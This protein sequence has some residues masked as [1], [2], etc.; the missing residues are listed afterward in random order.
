[1]LSE[2]KYCYCHPSSADKQ[3]TVSTMASDIF[4]EWSKSP[5]PLQHNCPT[6]DV[7][8]KL[9]N[10]SMMDREL[11]ESVAAYTA[12]KRPSLFDSVISTLGTFFGL[13]RN[14]T[15]LDV[16]HSS[17]CLA[18][19]EQY[20]KQPCIPSTS[21]IPIFETNR[22]GMGQ[23]TVPLD[24]GSTVDDIAMTPAGVYVED[25]AASECSALRPR[26]VRKRRKDVSKTNQH[27]H[28]G[29]EAGGKGC[30]K[31]RKEKKRHAL[32][33][34]ILSDNRAL[35]FDDGYGY[36]YRE[37]A[38]SKPMDIRPQPLHRC[39]SAG[40]SPASTGSVGSFQ[41]ALQDLVPVEK[42]HLRTSSDSVKASPVSAHCNTPQSIPAKHT[43][44]GT[45]V[46]ETMNTATV[47]DHQEQQ[48]CDMEPNQAGYVVFTHYDVFMTPSAS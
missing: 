3:S 16:K 24:Y 21:C 6:P 7:S 4:A 27:A 1:M 47:A 44:I 32:R 31:N 9:A 34:D 48:K 42:D 17:H 46:P 15:Q 23:L 35:S 25:M 11:P 39:L 37:A 12:H 22:N 2:R 20:S 29:S 43:A 38:P 30:D 5:H 13:P 18:E 36:D 8:E 26:R 40:F 41:D 10:L 45:T 14:G 19:K 33:R 28:M